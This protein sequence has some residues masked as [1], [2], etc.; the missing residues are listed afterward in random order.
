M[1]R[2]KD[3]KIGTR[4]IHAFA[5]IIILVTLT[6]V[7]S[8]THSKRL[9]AFTADLYDHPLRTSRSVGDIKAGIIAMHR[10]MKDLILADN[11]IE[12]QMAISSFKTLESQVEKSFEVVYSAYLGDRSDID[13]CYNMFREWISIT[14]E[15]IRLLRNGEVQAAENRTKITGT[16]GAHVEK[17][18]R[19]INELVDFAR[20]KGDYF[21][22]S[23]LADKRKLDIRLFTL[24]ISV[25]LLTATIAFLILKAIRKPLKELTAVADEYRNGNYSIRSDYRSKNE[26]GILASS[27]NNMA[28]TVQNDILLKENAAWVA[29]I[30]MN[31]NELRPFCKGLINALLNKTESQIAAIYLLNKN[32]GKFEHFESIGL[33]ADKIRDFSAL[34]S[35]GEFG[36]ALNEKNICRITNIPD[37]TLLIFSAVAGTFKP[38]EIITIPII[39]KNEVIAVISLASLKIYSELAV[40]LLYDIQ[41]V[42]TARLLG[43]MN[44]QKIKDFSAV[45][46]MQNKELDQKS[47][48][49]VM[50]SDEL[51]EYNI[52]LELQKKQLDES[53]NL[54]SAFLSNMSHELRT[55]LNSVIALSG[56]LNRR[57]K[58]KV[59]EDEF[60]YLGIIE[61]N[62]KNLLTLINDILDLSRIEAGKEE[63]S[64]SK[65]SMPELIEEIISSLE[66]IFNDKG[67]SV[68]FNKSVDLPEIIS[69]NK[70]CRHIMQ[71]IIN[72]AVKFTEKGSVDISAVVVDDNIRISVK[73]TGIGISDEFLPYVFDEFRQADDRTSRKFEGTGLGLAIVKKYCQLLNGSVS[74]TSIHGEGSELLVVL[75]L[76]PS[77]VQLSQNQMNPLYKSGNRYSESASESESAAGKTIL[78][79]EDN[80]SQI[81]QL[82]DIL[83]E[84]GYNVLV[85]HNGR[86]ALSVIATTIPDSMI[87][88]LQ[89]PEVDGFEVLRE[90]RNLEETKRIPVLILTAK[91]ITKADLSFL[92]ENNVY[93]LIQK[94]NVNRSDLLRH[95]KDLSTAA[96]KKNQSEMAKT[97]ADPA[98]IDK[99][100]ILLIEDNEDNVITL[101]ALLEDKYLISPAN[102]GIEGLQMASALKPDLILLD[103][104]L[105]LMDG[106]K[107]L[108]EIKRNEELLTIPVIALTARAMKG[109]RE[110][111]L[112]HGFD[113]YIAKPIDN[114]TFEDMIIEYLK[115][116]S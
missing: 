40:R 81:I 52:E 59:P 55:P 61:K 34:S 99:P 15:T 5:V 36:I 63:I 56:V 48:E 43:V 58:G 108:N 104:S 79:V 32:T 13:T 11:E 69:D 1:I 27:F 57:L 65:F 87:L 106:I 45:L 30:M 73:D 60:S 114:K 50:Q 95:I 4:L 38:C 66:P 89:M 21:Y 74:V 31:E 3:I 28:L 85:A 39:E 96:V 97:P 80:E 23:A 19:E 115:L 105:P 35:E 84:E 18:L 53:N 72:N 90:I 83:R 6:A 8:Y 9:W 77:V 82:N 25:Y 26:I 33:S 103:I 47:K 70:K 10:S 86:E 49:L 94:G 76:S 71:N 46:D 75:P 24:L 54:K 113:G 78:L 29:Q 67:I 17:M 116:K 112:A 88:D 92:K 20:S 107:V 37:D 51:K 7:V 93:Q 2:L 12:L 68:S 42:I 101:K 41:V 109:D 22:S 110:E 111:L 102:D 100:H 14:D 91:H 62:G 44:F 16:G 64:F 98:R